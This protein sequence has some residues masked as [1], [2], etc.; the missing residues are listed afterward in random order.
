M[1][2]RSLRQNGHVTRGWLGVAIQAISPSIAR[3]LGLNP[4]KPNGALVASVTP[5]SPAAKAGIKQGDV[6]LS[7]AGQPIKEVHDLPRIVAAAPI[8]QN[9]DLT[10]RRDGKEITIAAAIAEM[11]KNPQQVAEAPGG[12]EEATSLG[13]QLSS[14]SPQMRRQ[15]RIPKDVEGVVVTKVAGDSPAAD[16]GIAP[17][18]VIQS[19]DQQPARSPLQAAKQLKEAATKGS[20]LL[21]LNRHGTSEFVG[22]SVN[23]TGSST[24]PG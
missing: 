11:P 13:L 19:I 12:L 16:L 1:S 20:V 14:I 10:V 21:L 5:N 9:M 15:L 23:G 7:A 2:S 18:D 22:L 6:I 17:G 3:S 4:E 8:G 24:P